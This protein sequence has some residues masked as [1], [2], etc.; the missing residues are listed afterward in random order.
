MRTP[1]GGQHLYFRTPI[2]VQPSC[3]AG[4]LAPKVDTRAWGGQVVAPGSATPDGPYAV[5]D[6]SPVAKPTRM[7]P[8]RPDAPTAGRH[9]PVAAHGG[10]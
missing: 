7:A 5:M 6:A 9:G 4:T 3:S 2:G 10:P 1:S 8:N